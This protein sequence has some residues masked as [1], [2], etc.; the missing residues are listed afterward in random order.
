MTQTQFCFV[1]HTSTANLR[2][3]RAKIYYSVKIYFGY[4][5]KVSDSEEFTMPWGKKMA[6]Y[7]IT[8]KRNY[9]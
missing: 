5:N 2:Q 6:I 4:D 8:Y 1:I 7:I 3:S 9:L